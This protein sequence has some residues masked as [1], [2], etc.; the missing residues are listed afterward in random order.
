MSDSQKFPVAAHA[1]AYLAHKGAYSAADAAPSAIL[2]ASVPTNPVVIRRVTA[3]LAKAGLIATRPGA[4]GGSWLLRQPE[5]IRLDEVL[6][7]VNG[8]AHLGS[9]PA[10]AKGCPVG[11]H[12]PRQV[13]KALTAADE[14]ATEALSKITIADLL[15]ADPASLRD[16]APH[17]SC[18]V[19]A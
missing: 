14:A 13:A 5:T 10:G 6:K 3:L 2:A 4:S 11:E 16:F 17:S 8:C 7:A 12:I 18:P 9:T 15:E 19:A 1:L